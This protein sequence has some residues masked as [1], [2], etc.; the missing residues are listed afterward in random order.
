MSKEVTET[1]VTVAN[2]TPVQ[3]KCWISARNCF[4]QFKGRTRDKQGRIY[5]N[6]YR[7]AY[8]MRKLISKYRKIGKWLES[9]GLSVLGNEILRMLWF[10]HEDI[11]K[12]NC[13]YHRVHHIVIMS[14]II[15]GIVIKV[16]L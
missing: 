16:V 12:L 15:N 2:I 4:Y 8:F 6:I 11:P 13:N 1:Q 9:C 5:R 7:N 14:G 10:K 3:K